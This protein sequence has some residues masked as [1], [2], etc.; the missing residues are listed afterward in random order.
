MRFQVKLQIISP[1]TALLVA[2]PSPPLSP[3]RPP[4]AAP[5]PGPA[6]T[7]P[8]PMASGTT[9]SRGHPPPGTQ[10]PRL[11]GRRQQHPRRWRRPRK[12]QR[13]RRRLWRRRRAAAAAGPGSRPPREPPPTP[14]VPRASDPCLCR[15]FC[16]AEHGCARPRHLCPCLPAR[17]WQLSRPGVHQLLP[18]PMLWWAATH[19]P[20][21]PSCA[22]PRAAAPGALLG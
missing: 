7:P 6:R 5:G 21:H 18:H 3:C 13:S 20:H 2:P 8:R 4:A 10:P 1:K 17:P 12:P 15:R 11:E 22:A 19:P 9:G 14:C 16:R